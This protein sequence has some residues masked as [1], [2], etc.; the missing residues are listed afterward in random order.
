MSLGDTAQTDVKLLKVS[1]F[2][3]DLLPEYRYPP[4][5]VDIKI[6]PDAPLPQIPVIGKPPG[7]LN[8]SEVQVLPSKR[9]SSLVLAVQILS[10]LDA[11]IEF[12]VELAPV[13]CVVHSINCASTC[14]LSLIF[15]VQVPVPLQGAPQP[16]KHAGALLETDRVTDVFGSKR[17]WHVVPQL[18]PCGSDMTVVCARLLAA[19]INFTVKTR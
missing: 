11:H 2:V 17:Y 16:T 18:M 13:D 14:M 9:V 5:L 3:N 4:P 19:P 10:L 6:S 15:T 12:I 8:S 7:E 1:I